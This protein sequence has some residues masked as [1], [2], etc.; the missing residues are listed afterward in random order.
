[1]PVLPES[2]FY[3][4]LPRAAFF[5][6]N[7]M[8]APCFRPVFMYMS[9][10]RCTLA[11]SG[12]DARFAR[13]SVLHDVA[14][15]CVFWPK[16]HARTMFSPSFHVHEQGRVPMPVLPE[17]PFYTMFASRCVFWPKSH[18]RTMFS[19]SF[20]VHEQGRVPM[21]VFA[22]KSVLHDVAPRCVFWPKSHARN[23]FSPSFHVHEQGRVPMPVFARKSVLQD[24]APCCVFWPKSY[25]RTMFSC[26]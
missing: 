3:T 23:M 19:P 6:Q 18:A 7:H 26:T 13:K 4:I 8:R 1:M 12:T 17:S 10:V 16:S 11:R 9:K 24:V 21:P 25:A 20:H 5:G 2:P 14:P 22:R 15:R